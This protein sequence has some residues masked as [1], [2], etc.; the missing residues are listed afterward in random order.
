MNTKPVSEVAGEALRDPTKPLFY[1]A[2]KAKRQ[3]FNLQATYV[4]ADG[5]SAIINGRH[6]N[7]GQTIAGW[8]L[9]RVERNRV[10]LTSAG[11]TRVLNLRNKVISGG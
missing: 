11:E 7:R 10:V 9:T 5:S 2:A 3:T 8:T 4:R 6:I 1:R